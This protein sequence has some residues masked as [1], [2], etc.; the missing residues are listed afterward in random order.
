MRK[1]TYLALL[2][3]VGVSAGCR[4]VFE[5]ANPFTRGRWEYSE[6]YA[7]VDYDVAWETIKDN[8]KEWVIE[9]EDEEDGEIE[10]EWRYLEKHRLRLQVRLDREKDE[11]NQEGVKFGIRIL[12]QRP[13]EVWT[14]TRT[15]YKKWK[16]VDPDEK[17]Q[18]M[19]MLRFDDVL[20]RLVREN[21]EQPVPSDDAE[22]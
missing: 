8:L 19:L 21:S 6:I 18:S 15:N 13:S 10:S 14:P 11:A 16:W 2:L 7:P 12:R 4:S 22:E 20:N 5:P 1:T 17:M 3:L 9:K